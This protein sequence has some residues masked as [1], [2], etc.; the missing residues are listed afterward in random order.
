M[1]SR[2]EHLNTPMNT[3]DDLYYEIGLGV[4]DFLNIFRL[5]FIHNN[6]KN[7]TILVSFNVLR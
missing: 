7:N 4:G 2:Y 5:D 6:I 3:T 1:K